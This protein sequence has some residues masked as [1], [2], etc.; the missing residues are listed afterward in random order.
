V[1]DIWPV[2]RGELPQWIAARATALG[3]RLNRGA[4][5]LMADRVEGNLLAADQELRKLALVATDA[6]FDEAAILDRVG[7]NS[8]FDVF[9]L[10]DAVLAGDA[11]RA[12]KVLDGLRA[13]GTHP[14]LIAWAIIRELA[15]VARLHGATARG[16]SPDTAL[17]RL[18]VWRK[19]QPLLKRAAGRIREAQLRALL[20]QARDVDQTIKGALA[21]SAWPALTALVM[22]AVEPSSRWLS[23]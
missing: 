10:S 15:L 19:R 6:T 7:S 11:A 16:E 5:E 3:L 18:H 1:I 12:M 22:A 21:G 14:T 20:R 2:E 9:R 8:R 13:E 17:A 4:T 23:G